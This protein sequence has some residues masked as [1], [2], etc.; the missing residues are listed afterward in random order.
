MG[1]GDVQ[2]DILHEL[3]EEV[4]P[5]PRSKRRKAFLEAARAVAQNFLE[6]AK[7]YDLAR[8]DPSDE[9]SDDTGESAPEPR[10]K[11]PRPQ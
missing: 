3:R 7:S 5:L 8:E 9:A 6:T 2:F 11:A 1:I 4:I 10:R